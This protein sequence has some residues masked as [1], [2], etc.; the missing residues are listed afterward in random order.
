MPVI[1]SAIFC[2]DAVEK[3]CCSGNGFLEALAEAPLF[4]EKFVHGSSVT[5][6]L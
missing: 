3:D 6:R 2:L 5:K 1:G 4:T